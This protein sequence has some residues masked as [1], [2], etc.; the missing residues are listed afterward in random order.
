MKLLF[1]L[2]LLALLGACGTIEGFGRGVRDVGVAAVTP[3]PTVVAPA[4]VVV[5]RPYYGGPRYYRRGWW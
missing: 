2:P 4:P 1:V 3:G 5:G